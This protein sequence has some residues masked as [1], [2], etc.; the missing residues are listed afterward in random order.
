MINETCCLGSILN[1]FFLG[2]EIWFGILLICLVL[3]AFLVFE[4]FIYERWVD[5][6]VASLQGVNEKANI[7]ARR[8]NHHCVPAV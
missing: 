6:S 8:V 7:A 4:V 5:E 1:I 2:A 3:A